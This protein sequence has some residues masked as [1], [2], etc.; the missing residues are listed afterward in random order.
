MKT[1]KKIM[2]IKTVNRR[3]SLKRF[4]EEIWI[5]IKQDKIEIKAEAKEEEVGRE[6]ILS[7]IETF[8]I[9]MMHTWQTIVN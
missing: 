9:M 6:D 7:I 2:Q 1:N 8:R 4:V 3:K 5:N